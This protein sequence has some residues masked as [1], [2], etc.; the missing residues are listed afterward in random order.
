MGQT[1]VKMK[2]FGGEGLWGSIIIDK[3]VERV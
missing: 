1:R 2:V 3:I